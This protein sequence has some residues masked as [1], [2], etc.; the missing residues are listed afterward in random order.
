MPLY[1]ST[2]D[3]IRKALRGLSMAPSEAAAKANLPEKSVIAASRGPVDESVLRA[4]ASALGLGAEALATH[5]DYAPTIELPEA[6]TRLELPFDDETVNAWLISVGSKH[7]LFDTGNG[8]NDALNQLK[9]LGVHS[10]DVAITH[11]HGD[12]IG[13]LSGLKVMIAHSFGPGTS[14]QLAAG[15]TFMWESLRLSIIDLPGHFPGAIGYLIDGLETQVCVTGDALFA[16]SMGGCAPGDPYQ[17]A[18]HALRNH[19]FS[20]ADDTIVLPGHGPATTVGMERLRNPFVA[21]N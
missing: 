15:D 10:L 14:H 13:G 19:V 3:V 1:D 20:L 5:S 12:H 2:A 9:N 7:L 18:L 11:L 21:A 6:I 16:G 8:E 4:L 17:D